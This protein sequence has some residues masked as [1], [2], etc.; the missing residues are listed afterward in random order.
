[1]PDRFLILV[2]SAGKKAYCLLKMPY[3]FL[4]SVDRAL[5]KVFS[6]GKKA[7]CLL[8]MPKCFLISVDRAL[9]KVFSAS[10]R[11]ITSLIYLFANSYQ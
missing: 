11:Q 3:C 7:Y 10:K 5:L 9:L 4:I 2:F 1:M 8:K 6:A